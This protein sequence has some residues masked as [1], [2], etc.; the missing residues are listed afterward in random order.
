[1]DGLAGVGLTQAEKDLPTDPR[2]RKEACDVLFVDF[3][4]TNVKNKYE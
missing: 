4:Y 3:F 2:H 1:M